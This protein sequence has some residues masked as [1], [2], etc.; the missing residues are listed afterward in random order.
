FPGPPSIYYGD[1][2]GL[3]GKLDPDSR[4]GFPLE[5]DWDKEILKTHRELIALRHSYPC[6]RT[7]DYKVLFAEGEVYVFA[8]TLEKEELIV[9]VNVGTSSAKADVDISHLRSQPNKILYASD[10]VELNHQGDSK[11]LLN[12]P[13]RT[14]CVIS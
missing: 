14:G 3:P 9:A 5:A 2:V 10:K 4:R 11:L 13:P 12:I 7:G 1:E 8:R 6:L